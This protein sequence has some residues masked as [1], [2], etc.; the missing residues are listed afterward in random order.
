MVMTFLIVG[1]VSMIEHVRTQF[2]DQSIV[3]YER[4]ISEHNVGWRL[5]VDERH[6]RSVLDKSGMTQW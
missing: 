3:G 4:T 2:K 6:V 5:E 1:E